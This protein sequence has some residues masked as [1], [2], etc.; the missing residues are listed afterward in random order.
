MDPHPFCRWGL[1][2]AYLAVQ[3]WLAYS[4][5]A[6]AWQISF[7]FIVSTLPRVFVS[8]ISGSLLD[9]YSRIKSLYCVIGLSIPIAFAF[10]FFDNFS[11]LTILSFIL[12]GL[13]SVVYPASIGIIKNDRTINNYSVDQ[14]IGLFYFISDAMKIIAP[15]VGSIFIGITGIKILFIIDGIALLCA[16]LTL[17]GLKT[18]K[19]NIIEMEADTKKEGLIITIKHCLS[20]RTLMISF[21]IVAVFIYVMNA[22]EAG[23]II[24]IRTLSS[25]PISFSLFMTSIGLGGAIGSLISMSLLNKMAKMF[26]SA[27]SMVVTGLLL[28]FVPTITNIITLIIIAFIIGCIAPGIVIPMETLKQGLTDQKMSSRIAGL[29][30]SVQNLFQLLGYSTAGIYIYV[31]DPAGT[32]FIGGLFILFFGILSFLHFKFDKRYNENLIRK[33]DKSV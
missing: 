25:N 7:Y 9:R 32:Y 6:N 12:S 29:N 5:H 1:F 13:S 17:L 11:S 15:M 31:F 16:F 3:S 20:M 10:Y 18:N 8:P 4:L 23:G 27:L 26:I 30:A 14:A 19:I 33:Y 21:V 28:L 24:F 22:T 2:D